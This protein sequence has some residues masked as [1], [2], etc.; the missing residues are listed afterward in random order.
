MKKTILSSLFLM[1]ALSAS[2]GVYTFKVPAAPNGA[3]VKINWLLDGKQSV[4]VVKDGEA[5]LDKADFTAQYVTVSAGGALYNKTLWLDPAQSLTVT[6]NDKERKVECSGDLAKINTYLIDTDFASLN[7]RAG[8]K[9]EAAYIK[10]CDS[11]YNANRAKLKAAKL[12][13]AFN[14]KE[15]I[16]LKYQSYLALPR[17]TTFHKYMTKGENFKP[18]AQFSNKLK[19][20]MVID[21]DLLQ[22]PEYGQF[23]S[24]CISFYVDEMEGDKEKNFMAYVDQNINDVKVKSYVVHNHVYGKV[25]YSGVDGKDELIA[26]YKKNVTNE[27]DKAKFDALYAKWDKLRAGSPSP[28]FTGTNI[29][30]KQVSLEQLRGKYVYI[31]VWATWCGPCRGEIPHLKKLEEKY[32]GKDIHFVSLSCDQ[33]KVAW[34]KMV[35]KDQMTGIQLHLGSGAKFMDE[36]VINGIPRFILLDRTG[37]IVKADAPRPSNPETAKVFDELLAKP[38]DYDLFKSHMKE[39]EKQEKEHWNVVFDRS[40]KYTEAEKKIAKPKMDKVREE[41][42]LWAR[43]GIEANYGDKRFLDVLNFY[44]FNFLTIDELDAILSKFTPEVQQEERWQQMKSYVIYKPLN[45]VGQKAADFTMKD[46]KGKSVTLSKVAKKNKLVVIDFW[47][48]WCGPCRASMPHLKEVYAK[49]KKRGLEVVSVSLDEKAADWE[50]AYKQLALTWID[51]CN[52]K[53]WKDDLLQKYAIR[54]I[55]HQVLID[56]DM[57]FVKMGF[58]R[59]GELEETI[60]QYLNK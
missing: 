50:K 57:T 10:S 54:G 27:V 23:I 36:Y 46:H 8:S 29:E 49:Y 37:R 40:G 45:A 3:E 11:V 53:G 51:L 25:Q 60:E 12:P 19:Q 48:S 55:P 17:Y 32:H 56:S 5:K 28:S 47:A 15:T 13:A 24:S 18:G 6:A 35:K 33:D 20:L 22:Y 1:V 4:V 44:L 21:G 52:L 31:D 38:L 58:H 7:Y 59:S 30:G 39:L 34:E 14:A 16:R 9:A 26:Y 42:V 41:K 2:A 43:Q